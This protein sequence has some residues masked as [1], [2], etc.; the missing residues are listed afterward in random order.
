MN[1][2]KAMGRGLADSV[3][4]PLRG[5][6]EVGKGNFS[7]AWKEFKHIPG[8][9]EDRNQDILKSAGIRGWVGDHPGE[10]AAGIAAAIM[11]GGAMMGGNLGGGA[12]AGASSSSFASPAASTAAFNAPAGYAGSAGSG[13]GF[14]GAEGVGA[15]A[16]AAGG[17]GGF[18]SGMQDALGSD[19]F[20]AVQKGLQGMEQPKQQQALVSPGSGGAGVGMG[21]VSANPTGDYIASQQQAVGGQINPYLKQYM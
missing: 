20:Q 10:T 18:M 5:F 19:W 17:Q 21:Q 14:L 7:E 16:S 3:E 12:S 6:K 9:Q 13:S 4:Q 8:S 1:I 11:G 2:F 15:P